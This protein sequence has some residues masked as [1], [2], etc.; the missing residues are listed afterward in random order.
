MAQSHEEVLLGF[1]T[2]AMWDVPEWAWTP[3]RRIRFLLR[4]DIERPFSTD[5]TVWPDVFDSDDNLS[6]P[7]WHGILQ[8]TWADL[9]EMKQYLYEGWGQ[10]WKPCRVIAITALRQ[11]ESEGWPI[12]AFMPQEDGSQ[13]PLGYEDVAVHLVPAVLDDSWTLLGYDISDPYLLS[14]LM[15]CGYGDEIDVLR[16]RWIPHL[17]EHHLFTDLEAA[18]EFRTISNE[19]VPEHAPFYVYGIYLQP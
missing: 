16:E 14:G 11:Q 3:D 5:V 1:D 17:N 15:N 10:T 9:G 18:F 6:A 7:A 13:R 2:R 12:H 8:D 19:R 4:Q